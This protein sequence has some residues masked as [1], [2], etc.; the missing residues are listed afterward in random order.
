M[1]INS[2]PL[3]F[4]VEHFLDVHVS[5]QWLLSDNIRELRHGGT[6]NIGIFKES[7]SNLINIDGVAHWRVLRSEIMQIFQSNLDLILGKR[8]SIELGSINDTCS[9]DLAG[10]VRWVSFD[11]SGS[12]KVKEILQWLILFC[13]NTF[14]HF[15]VFLSIKEEVVSGRDSNSIS[16][17]VHLIDPFAHSSWV[18]GRDSSILHEFNTSC[19]KSRSSLRS[20]IRDG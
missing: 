20:I 1:V 18:I 16:I 13:L 8:S 11:G 3:D 17:L 10:E 19:I 15:L 2:L 7:W 5:S 12:V 14:W 9:N 6:G 4:S